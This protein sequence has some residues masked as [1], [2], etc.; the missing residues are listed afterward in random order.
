MEPPVAEVPATGPC[1]GVISGLQAMPGD[2]VRILAMPS[3]IVKGLP[4]E[5]LEF[6]LQA[7]GGYGEIESIQP[8]RTVEV[9]LQNEAG[10]SIHFVWM[11]ASDLEFIGRGD[12]RLD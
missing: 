9:R 3:G 6:L 1:P 8:D 4:Q 7:V 12:R 11:K 2:V 5:D 10:D